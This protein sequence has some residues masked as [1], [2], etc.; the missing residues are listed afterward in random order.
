M[1][2]KKF[3]VGKAVGKAT[4]SVC[5]LGYGYYYLNGEKV[6]PDLFT[7]PVSNYEKTLWYNTYDVTDQLREGENIFAVILGNGWYNEGV[8]T[9]WKFDEAPWRGMP[10]FILRPEADGEVI[11]K[12]DESWKCTL[13]QS[14]FVRNTNQRKLQKSVSKSICLILDRICPV[15]HG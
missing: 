5:G 2:R 11:L 1:F 9:V 14:E 8:K 3:Q 7:A 12:S 15:L 13:S 10:K 6:T 4:L